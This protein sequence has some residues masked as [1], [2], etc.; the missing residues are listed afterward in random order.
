MIHRF[1]G[2]IYPQINADYF[3]LYLY[4]LFVC[5]RVGPWLIFNLSADYTDYADYN[6][7]KNFYGTV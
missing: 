5:V 6:L 1:K 3:F 7:E 2:N 4:I